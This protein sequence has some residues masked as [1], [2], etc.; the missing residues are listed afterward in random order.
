MKTRKERWR[1]NI[2]SETRADSQRGV[3]KR[4]VG[5]CG[6]SSWIK[7][8]KT[9]RMGKHAGLRRVEKDDRKAGG[10]GSKRRVKWSKKLRFLAC[11]K[12]ARPP[13]TMTTT[14]PS[15]A[16]R[17]NEIYRRKKTSVLPTNSTSFWFNY[18]FLP[19]RVNDKVDARETH[20]LLLWLKGH[21]NIQCIFDR[22]QKQWS[23]YMHSSCVLE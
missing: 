5:W 1:G 3:R 23:H 4:K 20:L 19:D 21:N 8:K 12:L 9:G 17:S 7:D 10:R 6:Q 18:V 15:A 16:N 14:L 13:A 11:E 2:T 22:R